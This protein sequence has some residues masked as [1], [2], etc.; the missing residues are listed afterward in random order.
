MDGLSVPCLRTSSTTE[1]RNSVFLRTLPELPGFR[2]YHDMATQFRVVKQ[3]VDVVV[4]VAD[5][6]MILVADKSKS[7][8]KLEQG[9]G[10]VRHKFVF[11]LAL[12]DILAFFDKIKS[13]WT[14]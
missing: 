1:G 4:L 7:H 9:F 10:D 5:G 2:P 14:L 13:I 12:N 8:A 11:D 6:Q 3:K